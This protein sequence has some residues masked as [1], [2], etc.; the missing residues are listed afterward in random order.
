MTKRADRLLD[1]IED[2]AL[3]NGTSIS[4]LLRKVVAL[5]GTSGSDEMRAWATRELRGYGPGEELPHYRKVYA[6]LQMDA[7][8][9]GGIVRGQMVSSLHLPDFARDEITDE[10]RLAR[11]VAEIERLVTDC[12]PGEPIRL[13][14][15]GAQDLVAF[16]NYSGNWTGHIERIYWSAARASVAGILDQVRTTLVAMVAEIR[17]TS[18]RGEVIPSADV[19]NNAIQFAVTGKRNKI[20]FAAVQGAASAT[21]AVPDSPSE[22]SSSRNWLKIAGT[23]IVALVGIAAA[24]LALMQVQ[25]WSF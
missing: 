22:A 16:M 9:P 4:D 25:G 2:G 10:V 3:D 6:P 13:Q 18:P 14:P 1:E 17:A 7:V 5:G 24:V 19:G 8:M 15:P 23:I 21:S 12:E 11:G 20:T